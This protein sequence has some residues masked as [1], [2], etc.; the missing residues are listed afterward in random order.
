M[1]SNREADWAM[2]E[3]FAFGSLVM[4][5]THVRLSGEPRI[6]NYSV[7]PQTK[8]KEYWEGVV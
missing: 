3:A 5:G 2:G 1:L 7:S 4:D 6:H 8:T